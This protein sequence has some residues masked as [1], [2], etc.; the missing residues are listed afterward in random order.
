LIDPRK[1]ESFF[2]PKGER[3]NWI[4]YHNIQVTI[5]ILQSPDNWLDQDNGI[6]YRNAD[7]KFGLT[8]Y[9]DLKQEEHTGRIYRKSVV[10]QI[11]EITKEDINEAEAE[12]VYIIKKT[13]NLIEQRYKI[14]L[15]KDGFLNFRLNKGHYA[16]IH[17]ELAETYK[18]KKKLSDA[19][20]KYEAEKAKKQAENKAAEGVISGKKANKFVRKLK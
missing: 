12:A 1:G 14:V 3:R 7:K 18:D 4:R 13:A 9:I 20:A 19:D 17:N 2:N 5:A 11:P 6:F 15:I 16:L 8:K 10:I